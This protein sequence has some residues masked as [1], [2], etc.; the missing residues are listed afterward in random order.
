VF[1]WSPGRH[2]LRLKITL[3]AKTYLPLDRFVPQQNEN[4]QRH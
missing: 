2:F 4:F 1:L 3:T